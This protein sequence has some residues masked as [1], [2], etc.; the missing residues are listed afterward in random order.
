MRILPLLLSAMT[1]GSAFAAERNDTLKEVTVTAI[2]QSE[3]L[4]LQPIAST[5]LGEKSIERYNITTMKDASEIVPNFYIPD[6]GSRMTSSIYVRGL[7][8]RMDQPAVGLN[9]DN[10]PV[11]NKNDYDIDL[12]D[13]ERIEVMR[14][15]QSVLYGRNTMGGLINIYTLSP[16]DV[17]GLRFMAE[18]GRGNS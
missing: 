12:F 16:R 14:G 10:I 4:N 9:V 13:I 5:T 18:Y 1:V 15:P 2:K 3:S 6:Y 11:L 17:R 8:A 7:G